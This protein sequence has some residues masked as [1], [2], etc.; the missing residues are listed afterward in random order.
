M[1][2]EKLLKALAANT[3]QL[4]RIA[5]A[6][7]IIALAHVPKA[8]NYIR[9]ITEY[10]TFDWDTLGAE[11]LVRDEFGVAQVKWGGYV[12]T[13]RAPQNKF[14]EAVW[15]SRP[16]GKSAD[17]NVKYARLITFKSQSEA[18]PVPD[19]V[20]R[21]VGDPVIDASPLVPQ[22]TAPAS[23]VI[24][25]VEDERDDRAP[26]MQERPPSGRKSEASRSKTDLVAEIRKLS[27]PSEAAKL[28]AQ[29]NGATVFWTAVEIFKVN[30]EVALAVVEDCENDWVKALCAIDGK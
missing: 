12:W 1:D 27:K 11:V 2:E 10:Q 18:E 14:G 13:R 25:S 9:P 24:L 6:L 21:I 19:K 28:I 29:K 5:D 30:R 26:E 4:Q 20:M 22:I 17:G 23:H 3:R 8:P 15:F 7:E 16:E